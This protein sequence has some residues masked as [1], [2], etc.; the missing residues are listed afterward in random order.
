MS[1]GGSYGEGDSNQSYSN[2]GTSNTSSDFT[3]Q[4]L[5]APQINDA[6]GSAQGIFT[7]GTPTL[8]AGM[9]G[10]NSAA[11]GS[12]GLFN[13]AMPGLNATLSGANA[14]A[15]NPY[16]QAAVT[17]LGQA[18][19]PSIDGQFEANGRYG[20]GA[21]A[22]A[23]ASALTTQAG[24]MANNDY[25]QGLQQQLS[26]EQSLPSITSG[27]MAAPTSQLAAGYLPIQQYI[28]ALSALSPGTTGTSTSSTAT[29]GSGVQQGNTSNWGMNASL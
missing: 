18:I 10:V 14:S 20:S 17:N 21:S 9:S 26:A 11:S 16:F 3:Q 24:N 7:S 19:R 25:E 1:L 6:L 15:G 27:M 23:Y 12:A 22:N 28:S 5:N 4:K 13:T 8:S 29:T 2:Q